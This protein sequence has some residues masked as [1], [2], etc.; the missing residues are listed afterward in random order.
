MLVQLRWSLRAQDPDSEHINVNAKTPI[1]SYG[2][3]SGYKWAENL[4]KTFPSLSGRHETEVF[5]L[6]TRQKWLFTEI[7]SIILLLICLKT[8]HFILNNYW[9]NW[10]MEEKY[11]Y[12]EKE[13]VIN[14][15]VS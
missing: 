9:N 14:C 13:A 4:E 1:N 15:H 5:L 11:I 2:F 12:K 10:N 7:K 8:F 6:F 3:R